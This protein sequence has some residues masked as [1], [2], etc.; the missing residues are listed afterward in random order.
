MR[1]C[2]IS[3]S[4]RIYGKQSVQI[5]LHKLLIYVLNCLAFL[6]YGRT[7]KSILNKTFNHSPHRNSILH[8]LNRYWDIKSELLW[9]YGYNKKNKHAML[10]RPKF[11]IPVH[12]IF[13]IRRFGLFINSSSKHFPLLFRASALLWAKHSGTWNRLQRSLHGAWNYLV[14][15]SVSSQETLLS[16]KCTWS[17]GSPSLPNL[18]KFNSLWANSYRIIKITPITIILMIYLLLL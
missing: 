18:D 10:L 1:Q 7:K 6:L 3:L 11:Q 5:V 16:R 13:F 4:L 17:L 8:T 12:N 2:Q 14:K 9:L 15:K